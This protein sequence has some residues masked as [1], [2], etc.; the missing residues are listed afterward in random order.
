M[1]ATG[2]TGM[3]AKFTSTE[4]SLLVRGLTVEFNRMAGAYIKMKGYTQYEVRVQYLSDEIQNFLGRKIQN[5]DEVIVPALDK[6]DAGKLFALLREHKV[7]VANLT[8]QD[9][10]EL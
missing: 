7:S 10:P 4:N 6:E 8:K 1:G 3:E 9:F 2:S 5:I